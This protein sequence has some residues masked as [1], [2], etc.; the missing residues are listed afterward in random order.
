MIAD[1][2]LT[3]SKTNLPSIHSF[4][5]AQKNSITNDPH[6]AKIVDHVFGRGCDLCVV[7][8]MR[9]DK[10]PDE[11]LEDPKLGDRLL[12]PIVNMFNEPVTVYMRLLDIDNFILRMSQF[13]VVM[14]SKVNRAE[15]MAGSKVIHVVD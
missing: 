1:I 7:Y 11:V 9:I 8:I 6:I 14:N 4:T 13:A 15:G 10:H 12:A 2:I 5:S 3:Y